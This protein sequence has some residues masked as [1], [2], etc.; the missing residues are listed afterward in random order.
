MADLIVSF[1][2]G[3]IATYNLRKVLVM[4]GRLIARFYV[5][6]VSGW[7]WMDGDWAR[8]GGGVSEPFPCRH[9][10]ALEFV[11]LNKKKYFKHIAQHTK[12]TQPPFLNVHRIPFCS[13]C[14]LPWPGSSKSSC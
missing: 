4:N 2:V 11:Q 6:H 7:R 14:F 9:I 12:S 1:H 13:T 5:R 8:R 3:F 10:D